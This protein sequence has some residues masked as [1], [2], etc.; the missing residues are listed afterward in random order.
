MNTSVYGDILP[1]TSWPIFEVLLKSSLV[2]VFMA[3]VAHVSLYS[4]MLTRFRPEIE[5]I[6]YSLQFMFADSITPLLVDYRI[7]RYVLNA[8]VSL[9]TPG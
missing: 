8:V 9:E 6:M 3:L 2:V 1:L 7:K 5:R 4:S